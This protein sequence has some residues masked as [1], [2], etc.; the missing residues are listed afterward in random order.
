MVDV[1]RIRQDVWVDLV[2]VGFHSISQGREAMKK[3]PSGLKVSTKETFA[4]LIILCSTGPG[5]V[6]TAVDIALI[7]LEKALGRSLSIRARRC[8]TN[9]NLSTAGV[10]S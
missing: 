5:P 2:G 3:K 7:V 10:D 1:V 9:N 8:R 6:F 4:H